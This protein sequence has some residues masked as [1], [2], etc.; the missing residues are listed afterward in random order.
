MQPTSGHSC[1]MAP[2]THRISLL[3]VARNNA[4]TIEP[5]LRQ[6]RAALAVHAVEYEIIVVDDGSTDGTADRV[7]A[8]TAGDS[9]VRLVQNPHPLGHGAALRAGVEAADLD[10][11]VVADAGRC[12][13]LNELEYLL[14]LTRKHDVVYGH[15]VNRSEPAYRRV[16]SWS[17]QTLVALLTGNAV[18]TREGGL[19]I[20]RRD[21]LRAIL[22]VCDDDFARAEVLARARLEG[23]TVADI[24]VQQ[25][26][27]PA[28]G[29]MSWLGIPR[30][31]S[32]LVRFW[33]A[34]LLFP[35]PG[36]VC[37]RLDRSFWG[38]L[39]VLLLVA[40]PML[41]L[42]LTYPLLEPD[43]GRYCEIPRKMLSSG[44]WIVPILNQKP[45]Y[46]KPPLFYW[47]VVG[48]FQLFGTNEWAARLVPTMAAFLTILAVYLLGRRAVGN[49][50][51]LMGALVLTL[52]IP[53]VQFGRMVIL[54]SLLTLF[55]TLALFT[56]Y[57]AVQRPRLSWR[58]WLVSSI[59]CGL[60]VL[61]KGPIALVLFAP[62][63]FA[64]VWLHRD[65]ARPGFIPWA[66]YVGLSIALALPWYV[67]IIV[68]DP[69]FA[70]YFFIDQN[71][72]RFAY[73][74]HEK[75]FWYYGAVLLI[76]CLPWSVLFVPFLGFVFTR[77]PAVRRV[78]PQALGFLVL[79]ASWCVFFFTMAH[80]K[81]PTYILPA[82]PPLALALGCYLDGVVFDASLAVLFGRVR[83]L[84]PRLAVMIVVAFWL[85]VALGAWRLQLMGS[86]A[87]LAQSAL[88]LGVLICVWLW[89][90]RCSPGVAWML[91]GAGAAVL[92]HVTSHDLVPAWSYQHSPLIQ[93]GAMGQQASDGRVPVACF[94]KDWGSI[95]FYLNR[96]DTVVNFTNE[97][98][99]Q[100][101][102]FSREHPEFLLIV[103]RKDELDR[104]RL[105]M[106]PGAEFTPVTDAFELHAVF[107]RGPGAGK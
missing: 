46:D 81:L 29:R 89:G 40:G 82:L 105:G 57:E 70:R 22:P 45:F 23:L 64:Y 93:C 58:W 47:L 66:V 3:V 51:A 52:M 26:Q 8:I 102:H 97:S 69:E 80:S 10:L 92:V 106:G 15:A 63:L 1:A 27:E 4:E 107:V 84:V 56:G 6:A 101:Q 60:G 19:Q 42:N 33:W 35:A 61:T 34:D 49:R 20:Y 54:D 91:C 28:A 86:A 62:P 76:G 77:S 103:K 100:F 14:P 30:M 39:I 5:V 48:S 12:L 43:E 25:P 72:A 38:G 21:Q 13:D 55:V 74:Y 53:F 65:K 78:R 94:G 16:A 67:A 24:G 98:L 9:H 99:E 75:P 31:L 104:F 87:A 41:F 59:C 7:H 11:V 68:R 90:K 95:P 83:T 73:K 18:Q 79:S 37:T 85:V 88:A 71:L 17:Y 50:A 32:S 36:S 44:D 96:D 2:E